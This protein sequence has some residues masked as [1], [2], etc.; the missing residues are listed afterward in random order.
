MSEYKGIRGFKVQTLSTDPA[1]SIISTGAWASATNVN[2]A[3]RRGIGTGTQTA[4]LF[5]GG[6]NTFANTELYNGSTWTEVNDLNT[7]RDQGGNNIGNQGSTL[8]V[9][10]ASIPWPTILGNVEQWD[11]T[12]WTEIVETNTPRRNTFGAGIVTAA[13]IAG[14]LKD[15]ATPAYLANT[16]TYNG[17]SWTEVN[18][19]NTAGSYIGSL[20]TQTAALAIAR[21]TGP[22]IYSGIVENWNGTSWTEVADLNT[23]RA[24]VAGSGTAT[25]GIAFG[26]SIPGGSPTGNTE[27][28]DGTSWTELADLA[29]ARSYLNSSS[30]SSS[31]SLAFG[32]YNGTAS[33]AATEEWNTTPAPTFSKENLGQVYYNSTSNAFK[34]TNQSVP[35]GT[36]SSGGNLPTI[37][38]QGNSSSQSTEAVTIMGAGYT[39]SPSNPLFGYQSSSYDGTSWSSNPNINNRRSNGASCGGAA[40]TDALYYTGLPWPQPAP[41]Y[42]SYNESFNGTAWTELSDTTQDR[43]AATGFG[44]SGISA[45]LAGGQST[46]TPPAG[47]HSTKTEL[48]NGTSWTEVNDLNSPRRYASGTGSVT[49]AL[50][51]GGDT[52]NPGF[53]GGRYTAWVESWNGTSWTEVNNLNTGR[54]FGGTTGLQTNALMFGGDSGTSPVT[55]TEFYNGTSWTELNDLANARMN[56]MGGGT[57]SSTTAIYVAGE[58][59]TGNTNYVEEFTAGTQNSTI[60][61]S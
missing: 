43:N 30:T 37:W 19:M 44:T 28:Y 5:A 29:T 7:G 59:P 50:Y 12:N 17:S 6:Y 38:G 26:G 55:N 27:F 48:W 4:A 3:R 24:G 58:G 18:D 42:T 46:A 47:P 35:A 11:G 20:G 57:P 13:V 22:S 54:M 45:G 53:P 56:A 2:T 34:V 60:T 8:F 15:P 51:I 49:A 36:W 16:E 1:A 25:S 10:G 52:D 9:S 32:G 40:S 41:Q 21:D 31:A 14:G 23:T 39:P 33:T 61:V